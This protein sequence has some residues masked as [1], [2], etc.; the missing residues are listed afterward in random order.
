MC[1]G[2][3]VAKQAVVTFIAMALHRFNL[4]LDGSQPFPTA[5]EGNPVIGLMSNQPGSDLRVQIASRKF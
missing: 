1:P 4:S 5:K 2:R 3:F